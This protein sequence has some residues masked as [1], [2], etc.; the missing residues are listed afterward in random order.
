MQIE[1]MNAVINLEAM[2]PELLHYLLE[3]DRLQ[4]G[5]ISVTNCIPSPVLPL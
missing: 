2:H 1:T 3:N 4:D 5:D